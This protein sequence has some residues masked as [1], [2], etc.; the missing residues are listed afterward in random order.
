LLSDAGKSRFLRST[1][2]TAKAAVAGDPGCA[3]D[4]TPPKCPVNCKATELSSRE[5]S[6]ERC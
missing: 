2:A 5:T 1:P 4:D 6:I 3:Q